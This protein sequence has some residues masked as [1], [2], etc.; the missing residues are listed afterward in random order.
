MK[1]DD[2][3]TNQF[4]TIKNVC[5][6]IIIMM[7]ANHIKQLSCRYIYIYILLTVVCSPVTKKMDSHFLDPR[8]VDSKDLGGPIINYMD[9]PPPPKYLNHRPW[10][11]P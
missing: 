5:F 1:M 8:P 6:V 9:S 2:K 11:G 4:I 10:P 3:V 7:F